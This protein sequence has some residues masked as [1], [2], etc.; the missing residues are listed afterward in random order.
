M[1][2]RNFSFL[3]VLKQ[4]QLHIFQSWK[5]HY[6]RIANIVLQYNTLHIEECLNLIAHEMS[7]Y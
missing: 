3:I 4:I 1:K 6:E 5:S 2:I 7:L